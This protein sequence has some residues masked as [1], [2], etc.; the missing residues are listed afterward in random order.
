[1]GALK[2]PEA[3]LKAQALLK[4]VDRDAAIRFADEVGALVS[5]ARA[6]RASP[7]SEDEDRLLLRFVQMTASTPL[8]G[9]SQG[10][11]F[12]VSLGLMLN[13]VR[14]QSMGTTP[15][16]RK[17]ALRQLTYAMNTF[18][19]LAEPLT[20]AS[21]EAEVHPLLPRNLSL[22]PSEMGT[23]PPFIRNLLR[24][25]LDVL[26]AATSLEDEDD[27]EFF[28][29]RSMA[30]ARQLAPHL[31][32]FLSHVPLIL[33]GGRMREL[34]AETSAPGWD[35]EGGIA[36]PDAEWASAFDLCR[37]IALANASLPLPSPSP[38]GDGTI[39]LRW[40]RD[41]TDVVVELRDGNVWWTRSVKGARTSGEL[42]SRDAVLHLL[43]ETFS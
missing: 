30:G 14:D 43:N 38:C 28:A 20:A 31:E 29:A 39:H 15:A 5:D 9:D 8:F 40:S 34:S 3:I 22:S 33:L 21:A 4:D 17:F 13:D 41:A 7:Y 32:E 10:Q 12:Q 35:F 36:I 23:M 37:R 18:V 26:V 24:F 1:M 19:L 2:I 16:R 27:L 42:P 25:E 11:L 6:K